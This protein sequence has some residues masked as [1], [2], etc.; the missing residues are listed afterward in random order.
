MDSQETN[1][2]A[3]STKAAS[4]GINTVTDAVARNVTTP[5][6]NVGLDVQST[7]DF[8]S[9]ASELDQSEQQRRRVL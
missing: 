3:A 9:A 6:D 7:Q 8:R 4:E 2:T 1:N 5:Q